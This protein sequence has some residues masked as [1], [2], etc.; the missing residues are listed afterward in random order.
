MCVQNKNKTHAGQSVHVQ[1]SRGRSRALEQTCRLD[2][3]QRRHERAS[4]QAGAT[5]HTV[6]ALD[7][8]F[9]APAGGHSIIVSIVIQ[10]KRIEIETRV[11]IVTHLHRETQ[12]ARAMTS[13]LELRLRRPQFL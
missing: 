1:Q 4:V 3:A 9:A 7:A 5:I 13:D 10:G 8:G 12:L 11:G 6:R 2:C